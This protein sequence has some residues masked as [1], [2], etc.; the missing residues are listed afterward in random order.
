[1]TSAA[2]VVGTGPQGP[3]PSLVLT[4]RSVDGDQGLKGPSHCPKRP[5]DVVALERP[6][7]RFPDSC[8]SYRCDV[9]GPRK[10]EQTAAVM[11]WA[12]RKSDRARLWT[13]T[14]APTDWQTLRQKMRDYRRLI[15]GDGY[16]WEWSWSVEKNPAGTGLH[17][18]A[19]QHG[20]HKVP[21]AAL[22][23]RWGAIVDVRA[24]RGLRDRS[25]AAS[26][27]VKE[28]LKVA[29]YTVKGATASAESLTDHL[30]LNGGWVAHW[31]RNF[32][33]GETRRSALGRI[34]EELAGEERLTWAVVPAGAPAPP[35]TL[36]N[37]HPSRR[38][39]VYTGASRA[40]ETPPAS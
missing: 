33:H 40:A 16:D 26:Y 4:S 34:R 10:A 31:S 1:M 17:V 22:Q 8:D 35:A 6:D 28:A 39:A 11:T 23:E 36:A 12:L 27:T 19:C 7:L 37:L 32:L 25:G 5:R 3:S 21:Q 15:I 14:M 38:L 9:C 18:H 2:A 13:G 20:A 24:V 30:A 29:G